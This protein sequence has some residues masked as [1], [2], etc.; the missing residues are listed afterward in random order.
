MSKPLSSSNVEGSVIS[1][2][3]ETIPHLRQA[4]AQLHQLQAQLQTHRETTGSSSHKSEMQNP[5]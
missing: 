2:Y 4:L 5:T 3:E 1:Y